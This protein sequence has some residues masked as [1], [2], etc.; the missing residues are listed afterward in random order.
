MGCDAIATTYAGRFLSVDDRVGGVR[1]D[2]GGVWR[3]CVGV[4]RNGGGGWGI[5]V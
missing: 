5:H 1:L 2:V 4:G 3:L